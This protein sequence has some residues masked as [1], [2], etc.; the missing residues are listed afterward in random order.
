MATGSHPFPSRTRKLSL[1]APMVLG[2]RSPGR[3]GRRRSSSE[4]E[5]S[6]RAALSSFPARRAA[7]WTTMKAPH[8]FMSAL[9][10][11]RQPVA[12]E[13]WQHHLLPVRV[14][15]EV[16]GAAPGAVVAQVAVVV[17]RGVVQPLRVVV[18]GVSA[19]M[20]GLVRRGG[21]LAVDAGALVHRGGRARQETLRDGGPTIARAVVAVRPQRPSAARARAAQGPIGP[22]VRGVRLGADAV[23]PD[24]ATWDPLPTRRRP[25]PRP[26]VAL[27]PSSRAKPVSDRRSSRPNQMR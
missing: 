7:L 25:S 10:R 8:V 6:L 26:S 2:E 18:V 11:R 27:Q 17:V 13:Q 19:P 20:V 5:R 24:G 1:S 9:Q 4:R 23:T 14:R 12:C 16:E 15:P 3:V 22:G 21:P